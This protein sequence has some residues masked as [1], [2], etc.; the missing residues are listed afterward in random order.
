[1]SG[2]LEPPASTAIMFSGCKKC[3]CVSV[4]VW[5]GGG[6]GGERYNDA[7]ST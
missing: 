4:C 6:G 2:A 5:G 3:E 1:M 7:S